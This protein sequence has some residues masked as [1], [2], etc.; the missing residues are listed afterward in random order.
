MREIKVYYAAMLA[1]LPLRFSWLLYL[2]PSPSPSLIGPINAGV[3][4]IRRCMWNV[5]RIALYNEGVGVAIIDTV[6]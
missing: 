2:S 3:E 1:N 6:I 5:S 4:I